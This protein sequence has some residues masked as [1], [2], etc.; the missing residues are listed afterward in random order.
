MIEEMVL[1]CN[2][3]TKRQVIY[4]IEGCLD[5][6]TISCPMSN[7]LSGNLGNSLSC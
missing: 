1:R 3:A 7:A 4:P 6:L 2:E 5:T